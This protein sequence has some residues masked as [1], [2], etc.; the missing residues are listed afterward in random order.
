MSEVKKGSFSGLSLLK[1]L[2]WP[3]LPSEAVFMSVIHV[4]ARYYA[5]VH[6]LGGRDPCCQLKTML[7]SMLLQAAMGK[8]A[9]FAVVL[10]SADS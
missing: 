8:E 2:L 7:K 10:M 3:M 9:S 6:S 5:D 1:R 4:A